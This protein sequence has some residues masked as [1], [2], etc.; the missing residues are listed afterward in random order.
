MNT[1]RS[2][3]RVVP[4]HRPGVNKRGEVAIPACDL[5]TGDGRRLVYAG[6]SAPQAVGGGVAIVLSCWNSADGLR[7]LASLDPLPHQ[8]V[9][10]KPRFLHL[11]ISRPDRYPGW[12][13]MVAVVE[14]LAG[15][16][17]D[18]AMIKPRR[19]DC[20]SPHP[21]CFHWWEMPSEWGL[22]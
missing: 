21:N 20:V 16:N 14:A 8:T 7:L 22:W 5:T 3:G 6:R 19:A 17:L 1:R 2:R 11:S 9:T 12:D 4:P 10:S 18:M 13:E 15:P